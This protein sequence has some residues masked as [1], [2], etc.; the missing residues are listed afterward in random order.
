MDQA[1]GFC[2]SIFPLF[3][4]A[5]FILSISSEGCRKRKSDHTYPYI[6]IKILIVLHDYQINIHVFIGKGE[7]TASIHLPSGTA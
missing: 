6:L 5:S 1:F 4:I 2:T 7:F 3:I